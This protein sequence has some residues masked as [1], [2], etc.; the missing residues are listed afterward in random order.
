MQPVDIYLTSFKRQMDLLQKTANNE[1]VFSSVLMLIR[2]LSNLPLT[3][4]EAP[5]KL[6]PEPEPVTIKTPESMRAAQSMS[7][8]GAGLCL[9]DLWSAD[10]VPSRV[11]TLEPSPFPPVLSSYLDVLVLS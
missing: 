6:V 11:T 8:P 7:E 10:P 1:R 2:K 9:I 4:C 5:T 3:A